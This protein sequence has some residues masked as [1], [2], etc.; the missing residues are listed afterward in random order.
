MA[1]NTSRLMVSGD[2]YAGAGHDWSNK[3]FS[4]YHWQ[5]EPCRI[6]GAT[7]T[8]WRSEEPCPG[9]FWM[10]ANDNRKPKWEGDEV[11]GDAS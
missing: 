5:D 3:P 7:P 1:E 4:R 6:C 2:L 11:A 9:P 8:S 10:L